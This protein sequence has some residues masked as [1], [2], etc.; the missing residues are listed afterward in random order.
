MAIRQSANILENC[1][2]NDNYAII[3]RHFLMLQ[4][5]LNFARHQ[6]SILVNLGKC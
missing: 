6:K 4:H 2:L 3:D 1:L 5:I